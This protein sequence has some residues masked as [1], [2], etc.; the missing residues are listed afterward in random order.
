[1]ILSQFQTIGRDLFN[2]GLISSHS[3]N[4]SIRMGDRVFVTRRGCM[5][6]ELQEQDLI[7]TGIDRNDRATPFAAS[8]LE[9]HRAI[10]RETPALAIVHASPTHA[11]ALSLTEKE[12]IPRD[13]QGSALL[14][15]VSVLNFKGRIK[16]KE[17]AQ[18][19]ASSLKENRI[20]MVAGKGSFA[21]GQLLEEAYNYTTALEESCRILC[22]LNSLRVKPLR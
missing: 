17:L 12:I 5:L 19:V 8:E 1:M 7:E 16:V 14:P 3:G 10:Y 18:L 6:G 11:I 4:L 15:M 21:V 20:V 22:L 2:R 9:I 13:G